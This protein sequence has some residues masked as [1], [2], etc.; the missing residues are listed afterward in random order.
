MSA[1]SL[2]RS[3]RPSAVAK[4]TANLTRSAV[5]QVRGVNSE[6]SLAKEQIGKDLWMT[7]TPRVVAGHRD[8]N[9]SEHVPGNSGISSELINEDLA[10]RIDGVASVVR[11]LE[12]KVKEQSLT[13]PVLPVPLSSASNTTTS[14][15]ASGTAHVGTEA[16]R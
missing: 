13:P 8:V 1:L 15:R 6:G 7:K 5:E 9:L 14:V 16:P 12:Q 10:A 4:E 3:N 11:R 2:Q